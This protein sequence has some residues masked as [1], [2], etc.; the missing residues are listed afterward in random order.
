MTCEESTTWYSASG[1]LDGQSL[2]FRGIHTCIV[3]KASD[4]TIQANRLDFDEQQRPD[5]AGDGYIPAV[6]TDSSMGH[7]NYYIS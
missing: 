2:F 4:N 7:F 1:V 3:E 5:L 6:I